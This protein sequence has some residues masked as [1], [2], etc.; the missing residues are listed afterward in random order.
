VTAHGRD[1]R[2]VSRSGRSS[3]PG[4]IGVRGPTRR[5]WANSAFV[6]QLGVLGV[7]SAFVGA[8]GP[9]TLG[10]SLYAASAVTLS[11][12]S[13]R[14]FA[15]SPGDVHPRT[16][17]GPSEQKRSYDRATD[18]CRSTSG[19][20]SEDRTVSDAQQPVPSGTN[21]SHR[22]SVPAEGGVRPEA[23]LGAISTIVPDR[24]SD[25]SRECESDDI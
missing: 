3:A 16:G 14:T 20:E 21:L 10:R 9:P 22:G 25:R 23:A 11:R 1:R 18:G 6:G 4:S 8:R 12:N 13:I 2:S 19:P 5:S 17:D 15:D 24:L 7:R